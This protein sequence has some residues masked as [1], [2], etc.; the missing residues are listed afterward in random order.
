MAPLVEL[1]RPTLKL[2][3]DSFRR[4]LAL[5]EKFDLPKKVYFNGHRLSDFCLGVQFPAECSYAG[6]GGLPRHESCSC[7]RSSA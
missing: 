2:I 7:A 1:L 4:F 6:T 3:R 5:G